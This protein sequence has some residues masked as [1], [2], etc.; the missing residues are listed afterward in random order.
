M[1]R[2]N[3][4]AL[5]EEGFVFDPTTGDSFLL[6]KTGLFIIERLRENKDHEEVLESLVDAFEV[7]AEQAER[8][9][10]DFQTRLKAIGLH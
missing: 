2:L 3:Q 6:N 4:L 7:T 5:N 8:D 10:S 1:P 9:I